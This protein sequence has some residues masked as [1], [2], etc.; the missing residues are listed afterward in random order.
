[1]PGTLVLFPAYLLHS[2]LPYKGD[3]DRVI[4]SFNSRSTLD[5]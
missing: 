2:G 3:R 4:L 5:A 1:V